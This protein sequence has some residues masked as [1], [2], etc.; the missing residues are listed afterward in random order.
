[1]LS[2]RQQKFLI[3]L[4]DGK[5]TRNN[6][7]NYRSRHFYK[8]VTYLKENN[9]IRSRRCREKG[10]GNVNEYYLTIKGRWIARLLAGLTDVDDETRDKHGLI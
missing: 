7:N 1:M 6:S 9:I 2:D 10:K 4:L 3:S 5:K 8:S